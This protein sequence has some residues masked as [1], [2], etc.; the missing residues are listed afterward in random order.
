MAPIYDVARPFGGI[1]NAEYK[2]LRKVFP[3][4]WSGNRPYRTDGCNR[5]FYM[6]CI[7]LYF[8]ARAIANNVTIVGQKIS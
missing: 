2:I 8:T 5:D 3:S 7:I 1:C 4:T 6:V